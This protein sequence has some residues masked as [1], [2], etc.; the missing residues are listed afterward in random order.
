MVN[1]PK[2]STADFLQDMHSVYKSWRVVAEVYQYPPSFA[3]TLSGVAARKPGSISPEREAELR[4]RMGFDDVATVEVPVCVTCGQVHHLPNCD[5]KDGELKYIAKP[6]TT[7]C[8]RRGYWRPCLSPD[9]RERVEA[10][11]KTID[12]LIAIALEKGA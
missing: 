5:G 10:S 3:A 8:R 12:E 6:H 11:G 9:L 7:S 4:R 1:L 2:P